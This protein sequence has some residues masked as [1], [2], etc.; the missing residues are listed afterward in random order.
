MDNLV[1]LLR[2][3]SASQVRRFRHTATMSSMSLMT[4]RVLVWVSISKMLQ[5]MQH[6]GE[7]GQD[8]EGKKRLANTSL[9]RNLIQFYIE[10]DWAW[11]RGLL[12]GQSH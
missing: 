8:E 6:G 11:L 2:M 12:G 9:L 5:N 3:L 4:G 1:S 10:S 7:A